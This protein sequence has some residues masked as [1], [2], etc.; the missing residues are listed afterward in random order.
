MSC[1]TEIT[2]IRGINQEVSG[3]CMSSDVHFMQVLVREQPSFPVLTAHI[4][5]LNLKCHNQSKNKYQ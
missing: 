3:E 4:W 1:E 5:C 2:H